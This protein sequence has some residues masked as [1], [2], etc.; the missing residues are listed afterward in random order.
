VKTLD[1]F[2][3]EHEFLELKDIMM[4]NNFPWFYVE[5]VSL[6]PEDRHF[7]KDDLALETDGFYHTLYDRESKQESFA[8]NL[9]RKFY[10]Q[11][12]EQLGYT[13]DH[14]IRS[15]MSLK[16][17]K[18][19]FTPENYNLPHVDYYYPHTSM[20]FYINDSDGDTRMFEQIFTENNPERNKFNVQHRISPKANRLVVFNGLQ[21]H[22]A[23]NPFL[24]SRRVI[25]NIN[26]ES[27]CD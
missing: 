9:L 24:F 5:D 17:P 25:I 20:I 10:Q 18:I 15:R 7:V 21:Y 2:M 1:N 6:P 16:L 22:T 14:L 23:S 19:G 4:S 13:S 8:H 12:V 26:F 11:V 3:P 27:L